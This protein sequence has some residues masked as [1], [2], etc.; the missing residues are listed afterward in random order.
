[1]KIK[2]LYLMLTL[3][4]SFILEALDGKLYKFHMGRARQIKEKDLTPLAISFK[5]RGRN[6]QEAPAHFYEMYG[7]EKA[8]T[9]ETATAAGII[10][11][12]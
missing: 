3:P 12:A 7:L 1:M 8:E 10:G 5:L 6:A 2:K 11:N 9:D 4:E